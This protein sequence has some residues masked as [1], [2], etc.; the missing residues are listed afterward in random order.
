[1]TRERLKQGLT[2]IFFIRIEYLHQ[3]KKKYLVW[4]LIKL[5]QKLI[6]I[7]LMLQ[8]CWNQQK[9]STR[10]WKTIKKNKKKQNKQVTKELFRSS[11]VFEIGKNDFVVSNDGL[12]VLCW[13]NSKV[14]MLLYNFMDPSNLQKREKEKAKNWNVSNPA[15][16]VCLFICFDSYILCLFTFILEHTIRAENQ[17]SLLILG[18][19]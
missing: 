17:L 18:S 3:Q 16:L 7:E 12:V 10:D 8:S 2:R 5:L 4:Y 11:K 1:M 6:R 19:H 15:M 14:S 9:S 13:M